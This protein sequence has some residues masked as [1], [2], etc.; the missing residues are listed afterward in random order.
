[1][2]NRKDG[3]RWHDMKK[4]PVRGAFGE[5]QHLVLLVLPEPL[6]LITRT[7]LLR[8]NPQSGMRYASSLVLGQGNTPVES[9]LVTDVATCPYLR[10]LHGLRRM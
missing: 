10:I 5:G 2:A 8:P 6:P 1:M 9:C 4:W 3:R 7:V